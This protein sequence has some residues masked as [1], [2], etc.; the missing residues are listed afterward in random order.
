MGTELGTILNKAEVTDRVSGPVAASTTLGIG[1]VYEDGANGWKNAPIDGSILAARLYWN[2]RSINNSTGAKGDK[3]G[4]FYGI[5][6]L[7]VGKAE[8]AIVVDAAA[9]ASEVTAQSLSSLASPTNPSATYAEAEADSLYNYIVKKFAFY[10]G[11][12]NEVTGVK[13]SRTDAATTETNCVFEV[14]KGT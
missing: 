14:R 9:K 2:E 4:T 8:G 6:A 13:T 7:V 3:V 5:G 1:P 11:H 12:V 10:R